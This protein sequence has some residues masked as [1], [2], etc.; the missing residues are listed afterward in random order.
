[1][2]QNNIMKKEIANIII[3]SSS[4]MMVVIFAFVLLEPS[5]GFGSTNTVSQTVTT[6]LAFVTPA[7]NIVLS[8][9]IDVSVGGQAS[10]GTQVV[11]IT[12]DHLGYSMAVAASSSL[13]MIGNASSTLYIPA[14]I[15]SSPGTPDFTF[16]TPANTAYYGYTV[17]A[18]TTSDLAT[19]FRDSAGVCGA[20]G[21]S[22]T[23]DRCWISAST[24]GYTA[25]NRASVTSLSGATTTL[26]FLVVINANPNPGIPN[27][28]YVATTTLTAT[29]N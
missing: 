1:M 17:E 5:I 23:A 26:K 20:V 15:T 2:R 22:D 8:P 28:T 24:T 4:I 29:A 10:G 11:V 21:G 14:Y 9:S 7:T 12:N 19:A 27:D 16:T 3:N 6:E 25:I 13:G 18:S